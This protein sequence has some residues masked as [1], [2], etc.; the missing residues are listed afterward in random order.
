[1]GFVNLRRYRKRNRIWSQRGSGVVSFVILAPLIILVTLAAVQAGIVGHVRHSATLA[2]TTAVNEVSA[3][4]ANPTEIRNRTLAELVAHNGWILDPQVVI[5]SDTPL[6]PPLSQP[7]RSVI[8]VTEHGL[9]TLTTDTAL[10][11]ANRV[12]VTVKAKAFR[13]LPFGR[14]TV[15]V[16][17]TKTLERPQR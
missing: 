8:Q 15:S 14:F 12:E 17:R 7:T 4:G 6:V 9:K 1:M 3:L 2:A 10:S 13:V 11:G 5:E 16:T